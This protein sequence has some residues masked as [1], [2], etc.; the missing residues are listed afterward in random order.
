MGTVPHPPRHPQPGPNTMQA[1][2]HAAFKA[3]PCRAASQ[4]RNRTRVVVCAR[5]GDQKAP[6]V[7]IV[8]QGALAVGGAGAAGL[9]G[10][11][12]HPASPQVPGSCRTVENH[13]SIP[14][15]P[16]ATRSSSRCRQ[17]FCHS[18][19]TFLRSKPAVFLA[20]GRPRIAAEVATVFNLPRG[21]V[22][23]IIFFFTITNKIWLRP[24]GLANASKGRECSKAR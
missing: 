9:Q 17:N 21:A 23:L 24:N 5:Q 12:C 14:V 13:L 11:S 1:V 6:L 3:A 2:S 15:P 18:G 19:L 20:T 8:W 16:P 22:F 7:R 4:R 10:V